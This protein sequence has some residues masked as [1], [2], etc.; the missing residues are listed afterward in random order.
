MHPFLNIAIQAARASSRIIL[1]FMDQLDTINITDKGNYSNLVTEIDRLSEA[2]IISHIHKAYPN[3]AILAE[4]SG[5]DSKIDDVCWV[6]DPLDGTMNFVHGFPHFAISIAVKRKNQTE[7]GCIY[8]PI[9]QEL[10]TAVRGKGAQ[11]NNRRMRISAAKQLEQALVGTGF[12][13]G[14]APDQMT[15]YLKTFQQIL[16]RVADIRRAGS[17]A[18]DL[19]YVAA[20]RLDAFWELGLHEWD[21]AAGA[22]MIQ[23]AGGAITDFSAG[24]DFVKN[25]AVVAGNLSTH[26]L[27][28]S[29]IQ[30]SA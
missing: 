23:E 7:V 15:S 8:D 24:A 19:A 5:S 14:L 18:L 29:L 21:V 11:A 27:L 20:G 25:K 16:P 3:H 13:G 12:P 26:R 2:E 9:R 30:Q 22:L 1:R 6:I 10:F 4:E 28:L 17:A